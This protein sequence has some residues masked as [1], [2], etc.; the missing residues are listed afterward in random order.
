M[1]HQQTIITVTTIAKS[2]TPI[3]AMMTSL[4]DDLLIVTVDLKLV[5]GETDWRWALELVGGGVIVVDVIVV[6]VSVHSLSSSTLHLS[7]S[8]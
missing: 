3:T 5:T 1:V 4:L 2:K 7:R 8:Y 6:E